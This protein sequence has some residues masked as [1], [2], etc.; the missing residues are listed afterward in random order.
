[1]SYPYSSLTELFAVW[2]HMA[3]QHPSKCSSSQILGYYEEMAYSMSIESALHVWNFHFYE[4][5]KRVN[6]LTQAD[7]MYKKLLAESQKQQSFYFVTLGFDDKELVDEEYVGK[8]MRKFSKDIYS[9]KNIETKM[10]VVEKHRYDNLGKLYIHHHIHLICESAYPKSKV[11]QFFYQKF[12]KYIA[13]TN[14]V[15]VRK[16]TDRDRFEKYIRGEK[17]DSKLP[18]LELDREWRAKYNI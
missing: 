10:H 16:E 3:A 8:L 2:R 14:F 5:F 15:D 13:S 17:Q 18:L 1:M 7:L 4:E 12:K 11:I 9:I 6:G